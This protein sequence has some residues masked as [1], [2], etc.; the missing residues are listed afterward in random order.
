MDK[1]NKNF[2][3]LLTDFF[4]LINITKH[5]VYN[6]IILKMGSYYGKYCTKYENN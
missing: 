3:Y 2:N 4:F 6:F 5:V 1:I